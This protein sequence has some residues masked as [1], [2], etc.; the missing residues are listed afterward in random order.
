LS[1]WLEQA[2]DILFVAGLIA[3]TMIATLFAYEVI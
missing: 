2:A 1:N 3:I